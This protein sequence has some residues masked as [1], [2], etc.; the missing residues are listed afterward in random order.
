MKRQLQWRLELIEEILEPLDFASQIRSVLPVD[1]VGVAFSHRMAQ[2]VY[3]SVAFPQV[4]SQM[5]DLSLLQHSDIN[6]E[7]DCDGEMAEQKK[8]DDQ[9]R[10]FVLRNASRRSKSVLAIEHAGGSGRC[11]IAREFSSADKCCCCPD[12]A[13]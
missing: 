11:A 4:L 7:V 12:G 3:L 9:S 10:T 6:V 5:L 1:A 8:Q 13:A 2:M